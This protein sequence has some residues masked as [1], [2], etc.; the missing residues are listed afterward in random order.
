VPA[1]AISSGWTCSGSALPINTP[2]RNDPIRSMVQ[3]PPGRRRLCRRR[4]RRR[5]QRRR[6]RMTASLSPAA[7]CAT[8][9]RGRPRALTSQRAGPRRP[10]PRVA[11]P[12]AAQGAHFRRRQ[13]RPAR[14]L[15]AEDE[16][17]T[18]PDLPLQHAVRRSVGAACWSG[19]WELRR[20]VGAGSRQPI[21]LPSPDSLVEGDGRDEG[22]D[23]RSNPS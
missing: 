10:A 7:S 2:S 17:P 22:D 18:L 20:R 1:A 3:V 19:R 4:L 14:V 23:E 11:D 15:P 13:P 16:Q 5:R 9:R 12:R 21:A 6:L 8:I